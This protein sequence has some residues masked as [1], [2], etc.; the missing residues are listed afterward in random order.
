MR[1]LCQNLTFKSTLI[2]RISH[3]KAPGNSAG[4]S[5]GL[6]SVFCPGLSKFSEIYA[7]KAEITLD[8]PAQAVL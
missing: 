4:A 6:S 1:I 8:T 7:W 5:A 3:K 2:S